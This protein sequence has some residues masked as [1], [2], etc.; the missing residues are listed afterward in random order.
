MKR[1]I[2]QIDSG[3]CTGCGACADACHEHAIAMLEDGKA[4][5]IKDDYCDGLSSFL[6]RRRHHHHHPRRRS[7]RR[8]GRVGAQEGPEG[9]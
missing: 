7:V 2:V 5:L 3:K 8:E 6:P 9:A 4:H 1:K